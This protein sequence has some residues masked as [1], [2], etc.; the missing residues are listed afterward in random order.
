M[1]N[2]NSFANSIKIYNNKSIY[3]NS[4]HVRHNKQW[5]ICGLTTQNLSKRLN[6]W[7]DGVESF[8][9]SLWLAL[10]LN[11]GINHEFLVKRF[12]H[13]DDDLP[14]RGMSAT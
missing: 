9:V 7:M 11:T 5:Q 8:I 2:M 14:A 4:K 3:N 6:G 12:K 13:S 10:Q 1:A